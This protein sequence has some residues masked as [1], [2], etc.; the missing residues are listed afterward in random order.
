MPAPASEEDLKRRARRRLIGAVALTLVAVI[1][2]PLMMENEPPP[3]GK[4]EVRMPGHKTP[5]F[6]P[7]V[8]P[9]PEVAASA[10]DVAANAPQAPIAPPTA[11]ETPS[12]PATEAPPPP[13]VAKVPVEKSQ[14]E[15]PVVEKPKPAKTEPPSAPVVKKPVPPNLV[16][17]AESKPSVE[18]SGAFVVQLGAFVDATKTEGLKQQVER[19]GMTTYTD[20]TGD[21]TRLRIGPFASREAAA[22]VAA[23]LSAAGV[24]GRVMP[25]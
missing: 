16:V 7:Y 13:A 12:A 15:K 1:A 3:A 5:D 21:L 24:S 2:L 6:V 19:L 17:K 10:P 4:L 18:K 23:K 14:P 11:V 22:A 8:P 9:A 25:K 20:K